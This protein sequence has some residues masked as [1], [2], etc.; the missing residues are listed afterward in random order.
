M[1]KAKLND[2]K[3]ARPVAERFGQIA[4]NFKNRLNKIHF[5]RCILWLAIFL[6]FLGVTWHQLDPDFGWH[7]ASGQYIL[8]HGIPATDVFTY[9]APHF[10]WINVEWLN[11]VL[12]AKLYAFGGYGLLVVVASLLW[13][14]TLTIVARAFENK[15]QRISAILIVAAALL[16]SSYL[17]VRTELWMALFV[18]AVY[19]ILL[20]RHRKLRL[21]LPLIFWLWAQLHG[22]W[23]AGLAL[24]GWWA[25]FREPKARGK[26]QLWFL[27]ATSFLF[28]LANPYGVRE[29]FVIA[30]TGFDP[31]L[32]TSITEWM[33]LWRIVPGGIVVYLILAATVLLTFFIGPR[34]LFARENSHARRD[35]WREPMWPFLLAAISATR[36]WPLFAI[37]SLGPISQKFREM[38]ANFPRQTTRFGKIVLASVLALVSMFF[39]FSFSRSGFAISAPLDH[40]KVPLAAATDYL[41]EHPCRGNLFNSYDFG[42]Y[43]T[44]QLPGQ[45]I[46][47]DGRMPSWTTNGALF[48]PTYMQ[49]YDKILRDATYRQ[50]IFAKYNTSCVLMST[51]EPHGAAIL[52]LS[53]W[54]P[55]LKGRDLWLLE[56]IK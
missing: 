51:T 23:P 38:V 29:L 54:R 22:S 28:T 4:I 49:M 27:L 45:K 32:K 31:A 8:A 11:D 5:S 17:G 44:W 42:G 3:I 15:G 9:S 16:F 40:E 34:F 24:I 25:I 7:I 12:V 18:A 52:H 19:A 2:A 41:R 1:K 33:P 14:L 36:Y 48:G 26:R 47:I 20:S 55:V 50:Q 13:T 37:L 43:L 35:F 21:A 10:A 56:K 39:V 53:G 46:F 30:Q 6:F